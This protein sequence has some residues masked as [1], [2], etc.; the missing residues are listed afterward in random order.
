MFYERQQ[1]TVLKTSSQI[2][3]KNI[4]LFRNLM[5]KCYKILVRPPRWTSQ[6]QK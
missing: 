6:N 3:R 4:H 1:Q 2:L 5:K